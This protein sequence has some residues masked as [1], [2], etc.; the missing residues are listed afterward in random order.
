[1]SV[2]TTDHRVTNGSPPIN[3]SRKTNTLTRMIEPVTTGGCSG[4]RD[5]SPSG[6]RV[7]M[8]SPP[9]SEEPL[10]RQHRQQR[11]SETPPNAGTGLLM[12][13]DLHAV[14][15]IDPVQLARFPQA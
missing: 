6:I 10:D 3:S 13:Y 11:H 9:F 12:V 7:P 5:A 4:R 14:A 8:V 2:G 1:M 15:S